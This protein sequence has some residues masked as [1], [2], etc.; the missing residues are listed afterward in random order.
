MRQIRIAVLLFSILALIVTGCQKRPEIPV[1]EICGRAD[2]AFNDLKAEETDQTRIDFPEETGKEW[3]EQSGQFDEG[4]KGR[5]QVITGKRPDWVNGES[6]R[7]P[8]S[9]YLT[10]VGYDSERQS[11]EDKARAE[12][13]KIF[14]S[15]I[16]SRTRTYQEYLQTTSRGKTRTREAFDIEGITRVSTQKVLSGVKISHVYRETRPEPLF[17]VLAVL[18]RRQSAEILRHK[19]QKLDRDIKR[20]FTGSQE[21]E[22]KLAGIKN[23]KEAIRKH[24]LREA[25][26][27]EFRI[28]NR[29]GEGIPPKTGFTEMKNRLSATLLRDFLIALS[30]EGSRAGEIREA[31]VEGLN[32][33]GFSI[34]EDISRASVVV[35]GTVEIKP[36][37]RGTPE[38]RYVRWK[39]HFDLVDQR[40]GAVFGSIG[41]TGREGHLNLLQAEDR[42][43][44]KMQKI[45]TTDIARD[46]TKYLL[47]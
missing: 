41:E 46:I 15:N 20:L 24:L 23:L 29:S 4:R 22:D 14:Y 38:W 27:A 31:L 6:V 47:R 33:E 44:R 5:A 13:A 3:T 8:S 36:L 34:C 42:A 2:R 1:E 32:R 10:G 16:D 19:I 18:D 11:A 7:Y 43:V 17:Y 39:T 45:L 40:G 12:I 21:E 30:V 37:D 9:L 26:D 25:Y 35:R 28:V